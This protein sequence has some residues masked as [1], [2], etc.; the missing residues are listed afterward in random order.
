MKHSKDVK[1]SINKNVKT[2]LV[3][4]LVILIS[5]SSFFIFKEVKTHK[6]KEDK[7]TLY[8][9]KSSAAFDYKVNLKPNVLFEGNVQDEGLV[10]ISEFVDN[11]ESNFIFNFSGESKAAING[12][13]EIKA[14]LEGYTG[15]GESYK[16]IWKKEFPV[17]DKKEFQ[18]DDKQYSIED[19]ITIKL[20]KFKEFVKEVSE[21]ARISSSVKFTIVAQV[22]ME[23][24]TET[25]NIKQTYAPSM[26]IPLSGSYFEITGN[27]KDVKD[28]VIDKTEKS[29]IPMNGKKVAMLTSIV[30][31]LLLG[32]IYIMFFTKL[33]VIDEREKKLKKIFKDHGDRMVTI[34]SDILNDYL[35]W[36]EVKSMDDLVKISDEIGKPIMYKY[37]SEFSEISRFYVVNEQQVYL[38]IY[39]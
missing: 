7:I 16:S 22:N 36:L 6:T 23:A 15:E 14:V 20:D 10:Y 35:E 24:E 38:F 18:G 2:N 26:E 1:I 25:G 37:N 13:Y 11:I 31:V 39:R 28:G 3:A 9:Y 29:I 27:L 12:D 19:K 8:T 4:A 30:V 33:V 34:K 21:V 17:V 5:L 32:L